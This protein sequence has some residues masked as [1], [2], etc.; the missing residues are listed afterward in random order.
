M[1]CRKLKSLAIFLV[2]IFLSTSLAHAK[3]FPAGYPECW[4]DTKN[5]IILDNKD[6]NQFCP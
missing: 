1:M 3:K 6:P 5:P 2:L 4:L